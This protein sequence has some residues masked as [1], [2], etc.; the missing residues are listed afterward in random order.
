MNLSKRNSRFPINGQP[1]KITPCQHNL[2]PTTLYQD[3]K[4]LYHEGSSDFLEN[5]SSSENDTETAHHHNW[6][7]RDVKI[8]GPLTSI[9]QGLRDNT[10]LAVSDGSFKNQ[11]GS[12]AWII[13]SQD[14]TASISGVSIFPGPRSIQSAYRS[15]VLGLLAT[16]ETINILA[17]K[18]DINSGG[19]T[20]AC[21]GSS[22]L[23]KALDKDKNW[24][25]SKH[26]HA[27][28]LSATTSI[29]QESPIAFSPMH[30]KGHQDD[31]LPH[32]ILT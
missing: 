14:K 30:V 26:L 1:Q 18:F 2:Y 19:C 29:L 3:S 13:E 27:D 23:Q 31:V 16:M 21:N 32:N 4:F 9:L 12:A 6:L 11:A 5:N 15:K 22:A 17:K 28:L 20:I 8:Q 7:V 24:R 25:L 10:L